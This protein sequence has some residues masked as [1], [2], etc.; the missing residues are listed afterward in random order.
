MNLSPNTRSATVDDIPGIVSLQ[1]ANLY[2]NLSQA[3]R[4]AYGFVT[5]P[6]SVEQL[7]RLMAEE[8]SF[9]AEKGDAIV[10]YVFAAS[11]DYFSQWEIFPYMVS[12]FPQLERFQGQTITA[13]NSFQYGPICIDRNQRG[14]GVF[15]QLFAT[16]CDGMKSKYPIGYT[17]IN[18]KNCTSV[19]AHRKLPL[20]VMDEFE[21]NDNAFYGLAFSTQ[22]PI[23]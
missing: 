16:M 10:G 5:T 21:F 2:T 22:N 20:Q 19:A 8:G 3:D 23:A 14:T 9:V 12:R 17:F 6:F 1:T 15:P 13:Q 18:Q 4:L 11:W 7:Q